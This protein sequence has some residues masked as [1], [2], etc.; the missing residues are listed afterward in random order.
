VARKAARRRSRRDVGIGDHDERV[1]PAELHD[2]GLQ[3]TSSDRR[4]GAARALAAGQR[5][6]LFASV[7]EVLSSIRRLTSPQEASVR[8]L[9]V[10][11]FEGDLLE[12]LSQKTRWQVF[13]LEANAKAVQVA[14]D[15]GHRVWQA[16]AED[17]TF[18]VP[19]ATPITRDGKA[20]HLEDLKEG[21]AV[22]VRGEKRGDAGWD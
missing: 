14:R 1:R 4:D 8:F 9:D 7:E 6:A 16:S 12:K 20:I 21:E 17:A 2:R 19:E 15:K 10:G 11:C 13:G 22:T 3:L 5:H 18:V